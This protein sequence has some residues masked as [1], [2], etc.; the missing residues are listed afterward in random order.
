MTVH[1]SHSL[2][3]PNTPHLTLKSINSMSSLLKS[4]Q[5]LSACILLMRKPVSV[6]ILQAVSEKGQVLQVC[7]LQWI[8]HD[9]LAPPGVSFQGRPGCSSITAVVS[10]P[11]IPRN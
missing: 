2:L 8:L 3:H 1:T 10:E 11:L 4:F 5:G 9:S 6:V 7:T